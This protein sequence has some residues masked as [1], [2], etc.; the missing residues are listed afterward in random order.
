MRSEIARPLAFVGYNGPRIIRRCIA[1][2][3]IQRPKQHGC[4]PSCRRREVIGGKLLAGSLH[5]EHG[6]VIRHSEPDKFTGEQAQDPT[7]IAV[8]KL[9]LANFEFGPG[10]DQDLRWLSLAGMRLAND[11]P[12]AA[13]TQALRSISSSERCRTRF[14]RALKGAEDARQFF[15]IFNCRRPGLIKAITVKL[16][17]GFFQTLAE[18]FLCKGLI[19]ARAAYRT[20]RRNL[21]EFHKPPC[22]AFVPARIFAQTAKLAMTTCQIVTLYF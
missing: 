10:H 19:M 5:G 7:F 2:L 15:A 17:D 18:F 8:R 16:D 21:H 12:S 14:G 4:A 3:C 6:H 22:I 20:F 11:P 13:G 9:P 1:R